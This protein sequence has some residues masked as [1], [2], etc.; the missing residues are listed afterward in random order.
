[1]NE[2]KNKA[3]TIYT[4]IILFLLT[5]LGIYMYW[6]MK[7]IQMANVWCPNFLSIR[8]DKTA[9]CN[10]AVGSENYWIYDK[11]FSQ[12]ISKTNSWEI[13]RRDYKDL[14]YDYERSCYQKW[15]DKIQSS[16]YNNVK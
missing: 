16:N 1:M 4:A 6:E 11:S 7:N 3:V 13:L 8:N 9:I 5:F 15:K 12:C 14:S 2:E 10:T